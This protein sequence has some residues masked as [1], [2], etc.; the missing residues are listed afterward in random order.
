MRP[1]AATLRK[2]PSHLDMGK[3]ETSGSPGN[4]SYLYVLT[5]FGAGG[6]RGAGNQTEGATLV[7]AP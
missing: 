5:R 3:M 6:R 2:A 1:L 7:G 4:K